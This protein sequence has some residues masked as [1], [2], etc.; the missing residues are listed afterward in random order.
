MNWILIAIAGLSAPPTA[1]DASIAKPSAETESVS[2]PR[3]SITFLGGAASTV[4]CTVW[5]SRGGDSC[6]FALSGSSYQLELSYQRAPEERILGA[7]IENGPSFN[8][9][10]VA[11]FVGTRHA[12]RLMYVEATVGVGIEAQRVFVTKTSTVISTNTGTNFETSRSLETLPGLY[13]RVVGAIGIPVT[14]SLDL[15]ARLATHVATN[16]PRTDYVSVTGG[17][18]LTLP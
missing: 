13:G 10:G 1:N 6:T 15:V 12:W 8:P 17:L 4:P 18:R 11:G 3:W 5:V 16:G 2:A 14:S 9:L 7:A